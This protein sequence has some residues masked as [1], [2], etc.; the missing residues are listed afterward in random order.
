MVLNNYYQIVLLDVATL[1]LSGNKRSGIYTDRQTD[2]VTIS[3]QQRFRNDSMLVHRGLHIILYPGPATSDY[4]APSSYL[5]KL[6]PTF[7]HSVSSLSLLNLQVLLEAQTL[8]C[9]TIRS[10]GPGEAIMP[11]AFELRID[12]GTDC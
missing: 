9:C 3:V 2:R 10:L 5:Q 6:F 4:N 8:A 7:F 1:T 11:H 12:E